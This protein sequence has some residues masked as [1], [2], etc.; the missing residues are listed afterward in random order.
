MYLE[1]VLESEKEICTEDLD[2]NDIG[3]GTREQTI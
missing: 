3:H 2:F 1:P